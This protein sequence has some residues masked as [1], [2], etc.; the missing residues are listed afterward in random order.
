V[1]ANEVVKTGKQCC[2]CQPRPLLHYGPFILLILWTY[3]CYQVPLGSNLLDT[4]QF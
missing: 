2:Q 3:Y 1:P 4:C